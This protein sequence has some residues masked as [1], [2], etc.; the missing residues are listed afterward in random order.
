M[1][2]ILRVILE[3]F[4]LQAQKR[5]DCDPQLYIY[6]VFTCLPS[7]CKDRFNTVSSIY[8]YYQMVL[9]MLYFQTRDQIGGVR[10]SLYGGT[11]IHLEILQLL[12]AVF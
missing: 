10:A 5:M 4:L 2:E 7:F 1:A 8:V 11:K 12:R 6:K 3:F 9:P